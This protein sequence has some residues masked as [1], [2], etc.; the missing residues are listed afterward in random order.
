MSCDVGVL[1]RGGELKV[2]V[3]LLPYLSPGP[4]LH[5]FICDAGQL[6]PLYVSMI[7]SGGKGGSHFPDHS[8]ST[9]GTIKTKLTPTSFEASASCLHERWYPTGGF[10]V[11]GRDR[12]GTAVN[13]CSPSAGRGQPSVSKSSSNSEIFFFKHLH[14]P[15]NISRPASAP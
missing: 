2:L 12:E 8:P 10:Q 14:E 6:H 9:V 11:S 7:R 4:V 13:C 15:S 3:L 1:E 5:A